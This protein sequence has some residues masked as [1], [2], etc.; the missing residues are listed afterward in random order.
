MSDWWVDQGYHPFESGKDGFPRPGK[1]V[2]YYRSL[3]RNDKGKPWTQKDLAS[4]L[5]ISEQAVRDLENRDAGMNSY[6]RRRFLADLFN[7]PYV[8][9]GIV[10]LEE[11]LKQQEAH[12]Q[13]TDTQTLI[14]AT[15]TNTR[16][17]PLIDVREYQTTLLSYWESNH[18]YTAHGAMN[19]ILERIN[20]L[21][22]ALSHIQ[23]KQGTQIIELL[24][25]HHQF[26]ANILRDQQYYNEALDHL[27]KAFRLAQKINQKELLALILHRRGITLQEQ[28]NIAAALDDYATA[29]TFEPYIPLP[30]KGAILLEAGHVQAKAARSETDKLDALKTIDQGGRITRLAPFED[31][32]HFLRLNEDRYHLTKGSALIVLQWNK[33]A[34]TELSLVKSPATQ[35]RRQAYNDILQAQAYANR[36]MFP[37]ATSMAEAALVVAKGINSRIN[38]ARIAMI[39]AQFKDSPYG[40]NPDVA[41]LGYLLMSR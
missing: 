27:N 1:V 9:L 12:Q 31:D 7:I 40:N 29:R 33:E 13:K 39:H 10:S 11:I 8:L 20:T 5:G 24:C 38:I 21:Y 3:K 19:D 4:V 32:R 25:D 18:T 17:K 41:R 14:T 36:G 34:I 6:D 2:K 26:I 23:G 35:K 28:G 16:N 22:Q 37:L 30:L 15:E